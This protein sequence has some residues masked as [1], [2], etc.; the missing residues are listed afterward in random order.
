MIKSFIEKLDIEYYEDVS[1]KKYNTYKLDVKARYLVFPKDYEEI[2]S[3]IKYINKNNIKYLVL[4]NG[5]NI[6]FLHDYYDGVIIKLDRF[7][8]LEIDGVSIVVGAGYPLIRLA[9]D[10]ANRGIA[11]LEFA[12]AI[13]GFVGAS[14]AMNAG[15]Y[16][17]SLSDV[18]DSVVVMDSMGEIKTMMKDELDF[19]YRDSFFKHHKDY[20]VLSC[21]F[22]LYRGDK[23]EI[24]DV[25]NRRRM[26][27]VES[28]PLE[29][30]SAGSVFRNP[31]GL[32]AG[33][34]IE[35]SGLKGCKIGGAMISLK[36][37]NFIINYDKA[38]GRDIVN[39]IDKVREEVKNKYNVDLILEQ[40]IVD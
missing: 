6:I 8:K 16:N 28:Q 31:Q 39:L 22:N 21:R 30:P 19:G 4:G 34:L 3:L 23:D 1:L 5:S 20:I 32:Y 10:M 7:D 13:P 17:C 14:V 40:I 18:L 38:T 25:I 35:D 11:G 15:A 33:K 9:M 36:H 37:A 12:S 27:R 2:G 26:R 29:Y 24:L